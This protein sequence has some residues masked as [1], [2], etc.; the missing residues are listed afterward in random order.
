M[1]KTPSC[2]SAQS[3]SVGTPQ[4]EGILET[5]SFVGSFLWLPFINGLEFRSRAWGGRE[6]K[7]LQTKR[8]AHSLWLFQ[9]PSDFYSLATK[10]LLALL[11][12]VPTCI[13]EEMPHSRQRSM[14]TMVDS[15]PTKFRAPPNL[16]VKNP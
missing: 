12:L 10:V 15:S 14:P 1:T 5:L 13:I 4:K 8:Y 3:A 9:P 6:R 7:L 2:S 16:K 11:W